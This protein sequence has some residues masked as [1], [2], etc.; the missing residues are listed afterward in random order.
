MLI[1]P[2]RRKNLISGWSSPRSFKGR[3]FLHKAGDYTARFEPLYAPDNGV[4]FVR[5]SADGGLWVVLRTKD[6]RFEMAHCSKW[7]RIGVVKKGDIIAISGNSG[8]LFVGG[9]L[10]HLHLQIISEQTNQRIDP[11]S[12]TWSLKPMLIINPH[13]EISYRSERG[14]RHRLAPL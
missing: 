10:P 1:F 14:V 11:E 3:R 5:Y 12:L 9:R 6:Y 8:Q 7:T 4:T 13:G 2:V